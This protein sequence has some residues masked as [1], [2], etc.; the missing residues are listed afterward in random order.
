MNQI[1][2]TRLAAISTALAGALAACGGAAPDAQESQGVGS[3]P[4]ATSGSAAASEAP[5]AT[6]GTPPE[7][8][9]ANSAVVT[10]G[11]DR[12][13]FT[14]V[15]CSIFTAGYIQAGNY[16][17]DPEVIIVLPPDGWEA[18]GDTFSPPQVQVQIGS[19]FDGM[20]WFAGDD[21][22]V[23]TPVADGTSQLTYN[24]PEG[25]PVTATGTGTFIDVAAIN[26]GRDWEPVTGSF[27]VSCP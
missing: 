24:V 1:R 26:F 18:Q 23:V 25:R 2:M 11:N 10:I 16:G 6:G 22:P 17:E 13:E 8:G 21:P 20:T 5:A 12:Y 19:D 14:N 27:E 3:V 7:G 15:K 4:T 9:P